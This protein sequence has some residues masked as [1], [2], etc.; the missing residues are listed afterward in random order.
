MVNIALV[1][2]SYNGLQDT[3]KC[4]SSLS[5]QALEH[6]EVLSVLVDNGSTDG[7][8]DCV[9]AEFPWCTVHRVDVNRGPSAGNN[10]GIE[11]A[12]SKDRDWIILLNN[13][14]IVTPDFLSLMID[15][16]N[17]PQGFDILG[18][19]IRFMDEPDEVMTDGVRFNPKEFMG[20]FK[21]VEVPVRD[22]WPPVVTE[23]D[24]VNGCCMMISSAV[25][26][27]VGLFD[28][29]FFIYHD[30]TDYCLR[31]RLAGFRA[32]V[33]SRSLVFHKG[34]RSF[35]STGKK[36]QRY[37]DARNLAYLI[38]RYAGKLPDARNRT[39]SISMY[40]RHMYH[41]YCVERDAG[42]SESAAAVIDGMID[43]MRR[44]VGTYTSEPRFGAKAFEF[45]FNSARVSLSY[46]RRGRT[47]AGK[48]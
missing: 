6:P 22:V 30:E 32:G 10:S 42:Q 39:D 37:Y 1:V 13:D 8:T 29:S 27:K 33:F 41:R 26:D 24:V 17:S 28:E 20:F 31:A 12:R 40:L 16:A 47:K 44:R 23:V 5:V 19:V 43:A 9:R 15:L 18:P 35:A 11:F 3:R 7:T 48:P 14:T 34:G 38:K 46:L 45:V 2:L 21:R 25:V 36:G 4:L